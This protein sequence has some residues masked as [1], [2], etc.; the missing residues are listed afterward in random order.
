MASGVDELTKWDE[1][2]KKAVIDELET[3]NQVCKI[4]TGGYT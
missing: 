3:H 1:Y 2:A 4:N